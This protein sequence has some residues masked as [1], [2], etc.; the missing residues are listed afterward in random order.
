MTFSEDLQQASAAEVIEW[1][2]STFGRRLA[3]STSFQDQGMV[4]IDMAAR[5]S[6]DVRVITLDTG[7]L[8]QETYEMIEAVRTRYHIPVEVVLPDTREV[9]AMVHRHGPNLFY[10]S[11][12]ERML[13]CEIRK[14]RPFERKLKEFDA[15]VVGLRR[16]QSETRSEIRK[17][18]VEPGGKLKISPLADWTRDQLIGYLVDHQVPRHPLYARG[19]TSIGCAPC[20][21]AVEDGHHER[22]GRWWWETDEAYKECGLFFTPSGK[23]V[24]TVDV[25][26]SEVLE[27]TNAS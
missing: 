25:L 7:R 18:E 19:Y 27:K 8:P 15:Y 24:R 10:E 1:A 13:C 23:A 17:I 14:V 22:A 3:I 11:V 9:E 26:L 5:I 16:D 4:V 21:R 20:T 2:V 6:R 12:P